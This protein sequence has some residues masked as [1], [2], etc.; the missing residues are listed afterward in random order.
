MNKTSENRCY[1]TFSLCFGLEDDACPLLFRIACMVNAYSTHDRLL[2]VGMG[3][4][5][6]HG[7]YVTHEV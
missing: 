7:C 4:T 1:R 5:K 3:V 6:R 2:S